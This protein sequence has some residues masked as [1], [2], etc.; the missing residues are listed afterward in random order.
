MLGRLYGVIGHRLDYCNN[1]WFWVDQRTYEMVMRQVQIVK[2][3]QDNSIIPRP[4]KDLDCEARAA[5]PEENL[6]SGRDIREIGPFN[7]YAQCVSELSICLGR[8]IDVDYIREMG[9]RS[10]YKTCSRLTLRE[11]GSY[12]SLEN[13]S[14]RH[15]LIRK[16]ESSELGGI[17]LNTIGPGTNIDKS[18]GTRV[19]QNFIILPEWKNE[20]SPPGDIQFSA[21]Y[22]KPMYDKNGSVLFHRDMVTYNDEAHPEYDGIYQINSITYSKDGVPTRTT[23][24]KDGIILSIGDREIDVSGDSLIKH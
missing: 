23:L 20:L 13:R 4:I 11:D 17:L 15:R 10:G 21:R 6:V 2:H 12:I 9:D 1:L 8:Q 7:S 14:A 19:N 18:N 5:V 24:E 22:E 3:I 16:R